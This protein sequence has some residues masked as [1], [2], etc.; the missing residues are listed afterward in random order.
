MHLS[1]PFDK[2]TCNLSVGI[3]FRCI[4]RGSVRAGT[5]SV[6]AS[7][8]WKPVCRM[9]WIPR[10]HSDRGPGGESMPVCRD[11]DGFGWEIYGI[12]LIRSACAQAPAAGGNGGA[13]FRMPGGRCVHYGLDIAVTFHYRIHIFETELLNMKPF[14]A[15]GPQP[16]G[17]MWTPSTTGIKQKWQ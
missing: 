1:S 11:G 8:L 12:A 9:R 6:P 15:V 3:V 10:E 14:S 2:I 16:G 17:R 5:P 13:L 4:F 7:G